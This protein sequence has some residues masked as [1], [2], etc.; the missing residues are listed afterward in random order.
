MRKR[1]TKFYQHSQSEYAAKIYQILRQ[2]RYPKQLNQLHSLKLQRLS[3]WS[4]SG[5]LS[6]DQHTR[7]GLCSREIFSALLLGSMQPQSPEGIEEISV[8]YSTY[9]A[10]SSKAS[11]S[12]LNTGQVG[13]HLAT[14]EGQASDAMGVQ[15]ININW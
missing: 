15:D 7:G 13:H 4:K 2:P 12:L 1:S 3:W 11:M 9:S 6:Q 8:P 5:M 14:R 10:W